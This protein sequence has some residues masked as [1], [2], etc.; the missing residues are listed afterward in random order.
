MC[1]GGNFFKKILPIAALAAGAYFTGGGSLGGLFGSSAAEGAGAAAAGAGTE[2][3]SG[4]GLGS[5]LAAEGGGLF[6]SGLGSA[7]T[8][9]LNFAKDNAFWVGQG[10]NAA[11]VGANYIARQ[12]S[13]DDFNKYSAEYQNK[14]N[15]LQSQANDI[16][17][18]SLTGFNVGN[19]TA[20]VGD[21]YKNRLQASQATQMNPQSIYMPTSDSAPKEIK[22]ANADKISD[23]LNLGR[24]ES[25]AGAK[26]FSYNDVNNTNNMNLAES[27]RKI[28]TLS[29]FQAGNGNTFNAQVQ[30]NMATPR[31]METI[32][33]LLQGTGAIANAYASTRP[34][35]LTV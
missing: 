25:K 24:D 18:N 6:S 15:A 20:M 4:A 21:A 5:G 23:I 10:L 26:L 11:G 16:N 9:G 17:N 13:L 19:Q 12:Q 33:G 28:G 27:G 34:K 1:I 35:K 30:Q 31:P 14:T 3:F 22:T 2:A 29:N 32:G 7:L 8:S